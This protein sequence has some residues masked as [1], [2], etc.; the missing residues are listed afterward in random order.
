[1]PI[2]KVFPWVKPQ[3]EARYWDYDQPPD[4][5]STKSLVSTSLEGLKKAGFDVSAWEGSA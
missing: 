2:G 4:V 1:M 5:V 3:A